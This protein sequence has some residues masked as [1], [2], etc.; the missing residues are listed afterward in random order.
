MKQKLIQ[1]LTLDSALTN[2]HK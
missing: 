1:Q 2:M